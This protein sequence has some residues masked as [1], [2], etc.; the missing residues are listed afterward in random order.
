[1]IDISKDIEKYLVKD[2]VVEKKFRLKG[3]TAY[4][5]TNRLFIK[6]GSGDIHKLLNSEID[7]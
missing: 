4:A 2:K 1:M 5:S 3:Q 7:R 6:K